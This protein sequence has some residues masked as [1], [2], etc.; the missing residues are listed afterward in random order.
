MFE[1]Q[2][3]FLQRQTILV[4]AQALR[5]KVSSLIPALWL[6]PGFDQL[7]CAG[8]PAS[9]QLPYSSDIQV[10]PMA[11]GTSNPQRTLV[12]RAMGGGS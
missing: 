9:P 12:L 5:R 4:N 10:C 8:G 3:Y 6:F 11:H 7:R 2:I 1:S